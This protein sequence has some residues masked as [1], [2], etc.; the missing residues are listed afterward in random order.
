MAITRTPKG[1]ATSK[2]SGNTLTL[3]SVQILAGSSLVVGVAYDTGQGAPTVTWGNRELSQIQVQ[4][5]SGAAT[6]LFLLRHVNNDRTRTISC[7][8]GGNIT[9]K[10]M[11][12]TM[13]TVAQI[14]DVSQSAGQA[15]TTDP[16]TGAAVTSTDPDTISIAAFGVQ[17]PPSDTIGTVGSGHTSGQRAGTS[18]APPASNI[19]IHETF[20]ILTATG[21]V[22]ATKTGATSRSWANTIAALK[23]SK[24]WS[25]RSISPSE[26]NDLEELFEAS[27]IDF[28]NHAFRY[29]SSIDTWEIYDVTDIGTL[30]ATRTNGTNVWE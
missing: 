20:E 1:T 10:A 17:G 23:N 7:T 29:N 25:T 6:A 16:A 21:N 8:W 3:A 27:N 4:A 24:R 2:V 12:A 13:I 5:Q 18:G 19:T 22:R 9:A 15:A 30:V 14:A 11:F 26:F 28:D